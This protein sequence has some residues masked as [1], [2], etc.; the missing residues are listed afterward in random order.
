MANKPKICDG[1][2]TVSLTNGV[3]ERGQQH[4]NNETGALSYTTHK[5]N[6][7]C[8]KDLILRPRTIKFLEENIG[9]KV[10]DIVL[11]DDFLNLPPKVKV[12]KA[13]INKLDYIKLKSFCTAKETHQQNKKAT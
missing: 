11:G 10:P 9:G 13:K 8:T 6:S 2:R 7:K 1:E 4:A 12:T 5:M 3:G